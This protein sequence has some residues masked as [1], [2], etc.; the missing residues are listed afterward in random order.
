MSQPNSP[1]VASVES[2]FVTLQ[3][4]FIP[5]AE[6]HFWD[7]SNWTKAKLL[8]SLQK[9]LQFRFVTCP[10]GM[11]ALSQLVFGSG[12]GFETRQGTNQGDSKPQSMTMLLLENYIVKPAV[13]IM[14][15]QAFEESNKSAPRSLPDNDTIGQALNVSNEE[16]LMELHDANNHKSPWTMTYLQF[17]GRRRD[18]EIE[19]LQDQPIANFR[20]NNDLLGPSLIMGKFSMLPL[21]LRRAVWEKVDFQEG[22]IITIDAPNQRFSRIVQVLPEHPSNS[23]KPYRRID[24]FITKEAHQAVIDMLD[25]HLYVND[26]ATAGP[27]TRKIY[28][29]NQLGDVVFINN[30]KVAGRSLSGTAIQVGLNG[31]F[32]RGVKTLALHDR[33]LFLW[34]VGATN[35]D[36]EFAVIG[37]ILSKF[38]Q[39][40]QLLIVLA[41]SS[42]SVN[43]TGDM[44]LIDV[45]ERSP[46][47]ISLE[48]D[49]SRFSTGYGD[50]DRCIMNWSTRSTT[51][52]VIRQL[53]N[54]FAMNHPEWK[55]PTLRFMRI[56]QWYEIADKARYKVAG[57][58]IVENRGEGSLYQKVA[59]DRLKNH[60]I[61]LIM[62]SVKQALGCGST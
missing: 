5:T 44:K 18:M 43:L 27:N 11:G 20:N 34:K 62:K 39:L 52:R 59:G 47:N 6:N 37:K 26:S 36:E 51:P 55:T 54:T 15:R 28:F 57:G 16:E 23:I 10:W 29:S 61:A 1:A 13:S 7:F 49:T 21:E 4:N 60:K 42:A 35:D 19:L 2:I 41:P 22:H 38:T 53:F 58:Q 56:A 40:E 24:H 33:N 48:N 30:L 12:Q 8:Y 3:M 31:S 17:M 50:D 14:M 46:S 25:G 32:E 45:E 9:R